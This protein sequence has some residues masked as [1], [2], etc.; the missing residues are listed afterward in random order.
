[1]LVRSLTKWSCQFGNCDLEFGDGKAGQDLTLNF[2]PLVAVQADSKIILVISSISR[3]RQ[4]G[5]GQKWQHSLRESLD[6]GK[7][8]QNLDNLTT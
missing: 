1:M 4:R 7:I 8:G 3:C 5:N 6:T 2:S